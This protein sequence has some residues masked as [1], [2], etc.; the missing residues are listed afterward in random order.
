MSVSLNSSGKIGQEMMECIF[1]EE[2]FED[3]GINEVYIVLKIYHWMDGISALK[4]E[5]AS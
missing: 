5:L 2:E 3:G 1:C 4:Q